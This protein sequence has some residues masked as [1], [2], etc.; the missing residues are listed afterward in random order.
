MCRGKGPHFKL[1]R[2]NRH[3]LQRDQGLEAF[4]DQIPKT[5]RDAVTLTR[6]I[7]EDYLWVDA[8]CIVQDDPDDK[9]RQIKHMGNIYRYSV[10][11]I[12]ARSGDDSNS[13]IP[14]VDPD[15]RD[16]PQML[17]IAGK[18]VLCNVLATD[19][20]EDYSTA[21]PWDTRAW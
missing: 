8:L 5:I 10:L 11:T 21:M 15:S 16:V 3:W 7:G 18:S 9:A 1:E 4:W 6:A 14:G 13:G 12:I 19:D 20:E 17:G 2:Q